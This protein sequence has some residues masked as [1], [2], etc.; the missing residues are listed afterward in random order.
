MLNYKKYRKQIEK[1]YEDLATISRHVKAKKL[2]GETKLER[3]VVYND[4]PCRLSQ[5]ALSAGYQTEAANEIA[6]ETKL[7]IQPELEIKPGDIV[8]INRLRLGPMSEYT[9]GESF[10]Y[11]SHQ[12]VILTQEAKA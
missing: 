6:Y 7:F 12:E 11:G 8:A 2:S 5:K 9:A 1:L 4:V 3:Q 10:L